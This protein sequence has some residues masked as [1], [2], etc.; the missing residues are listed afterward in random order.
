MLRV[1]AKDGSRHRLLATGLVAIG[2]VPI[3]LV[4]IGLAPI[5]Y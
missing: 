1:T 4:A 2:L 5:T 3:G